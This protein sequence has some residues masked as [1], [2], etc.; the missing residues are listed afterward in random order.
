[1]DK[2]FKQ[3]AP[4]IMVGIILV[5]LF[6]GIMLLAYLFILGATI[7]LILFALRFIQKKFFPPKKVS[8]PRTSGRIIDSD[9][10]K[11]L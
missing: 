2:L 11:K 1:M 10:W 8:K 7:G 4:F 5:V 9:E 3:L 6:F